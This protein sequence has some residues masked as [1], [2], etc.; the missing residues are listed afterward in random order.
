MFKSYAIFSAIAKNKD[1][2]STIV[3]S[4]LLSLPVLPRFFFS[5][6]LNFFCP[7]LEGGKFFFNT[8]R[9]GDSV[10]FAT[11]DEQVLRPFFC[12]TSEAK[13]IFKN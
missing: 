1:R 10:L 13:T 6:K 5:C 9:E 2:G 3:K 4:I 12:G 8:V 11:E 7:D